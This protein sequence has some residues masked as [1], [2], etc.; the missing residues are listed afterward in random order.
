[1]MFIPNLLS[2][3][4]GSQS[5]VRARIVVVEDEPDL[6][7]AVAEYLGASGYDVATAESAAAARTLLETQSFHLAILDI[8][9]PGEDGLSF[10]RWLRSKTPIGIIYATAAGTALD[11]IVGLELGADDYIVKPYE[12]REVLARVRSVLR[13]VPQ[14]AEPQA[15]KPETGAGRRMSF[16]AFHADLDGRLVTG[17]NGAVV[18]MAKSEFDVLEVFL[19]RANR[20]LTRAAISE[21]IGFVEDPES[22]R[23]VDIRIMRLRKKIEAD[24]ANPKFLRTV[25]GEGYIFSLPAG[26][27]N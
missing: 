9:M 14:P 1:M 7:D 10:G 27:G 8:A 5:I 3:E 20:L 23:A 6:R 11:R 21:A 12:L 4:S 13:R 26:E 18:D 15:A 19:T 2:A 22:S 16:G 24:P 17:A 25:R